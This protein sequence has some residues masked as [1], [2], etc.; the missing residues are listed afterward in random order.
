MRI[1]AAASLALLVCLF[2]DQG[3]RISRSS[4]DFLSANSD[5]RFANSFH[6]ELA[7]AS[8]EQQSRIWS[9]A[10]RR[11]MHYGVLPSNCAPDIPSLF[12]ERH[13]AEAGCQDPTTHS[14][15]NDR[16]PPALTA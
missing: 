1:Q 12:A 15:P 9:K 10:P 16:G 5:R 4:R 3:S 7:V 8:L 11:Q 6:R 14:L 2:A 13:S